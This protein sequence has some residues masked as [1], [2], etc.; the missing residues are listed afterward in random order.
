LKIR[1][2]GLF[3]Y[4]L[5][6]SAILVAFSAA[7]YSV[8]GL[9]SLFAGA[10]TQ[11]IIM[12][13]S[14]EFAKLILASLLYRY[15]SVINKM[16]KTYFSIALIVLMAITSAGIY[17]Y[18]SD[19]YSSTSSKLDVIGKKVEYLN[20]TKK[21]KQ[22]EYDRYKSRY[23]I[24]V[25]SRTQ[26]ETRLDTLY[27]RKYTVSAKRTEDLISKSSNDI[28]TLDSN[29]NQKMQEISKVDE[30][31]LQLQN[32]NISGEVGPLRYISKLTGK[33]MDEVSSWFILLLII[34]FDPLAVSLVIATNLVIIHEFKKKD[35]VPDIV[36]E[37]EKK[38]FQ[39][40]FLTK[41]KIEEKKEI[42]IPEIIEKTEEKEIVS[43]ENVY[44]EKYPDSEERKE[45]R[46]WLTTKGGGVIP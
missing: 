32:E 10:K 12:A 36:E 17:G 33:S 3:K 18:L 16:M 19:A 46:H 11:V 31:I 45:K 8:F 30:D 26:Q 21:Q 5:G 28:H 9:S 23:D 2:K 39:L 38:P 42:V 14:L 27:N 4:L 6:V 44:D 7:F 20:L 13:S 34:V 41:N 25:N 15:W 37:K 43:E 24:L 29:M 1:T 35:I 40:P 22:S